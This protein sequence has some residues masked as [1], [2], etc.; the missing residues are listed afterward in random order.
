M[1]HATLFAAA[2]GALAA[3]GEGA[4]STPETLTLVKIDSRLSFLPIA[5]GHNQPGTGGQGISVKD[6][7]QTAQLATNDELYVYNHVTKDYNIFRLVQETELVSLGTNDQGEAVTTNVDYKVWQPQRAIVIGADG[8]AAERMS[9]GVDTPLDNGYGLWLHRKGESV[10]SVVWATGSYATNVVSV[11]APGTYGLVGLPG[12]ADDVDIDDL[13]TFPES[14]S[15][16]EGD[17]LFR[18]VENGDLVQFRF[19]GGKWNLMSLSYSGPHTLSR[20]QAF[21]F[22]HPATAEK[23]I[24]FAWR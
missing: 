24:V 5:I 15:F 12:W 18:V 1:R 17:L 6:V 16:V 3:F 2:F 22:K 21:W 10:N 4:V 23:D 19:A 9:V 20:G 7:V 11:V 13:K 8:E 14:C